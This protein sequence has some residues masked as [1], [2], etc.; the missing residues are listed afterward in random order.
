MACRASPST[1]ASSFA[2]KD[3]V[4]ACRV[5]VDRYREVAGITPDVKVSLPD[6][7][8]LEEDLAEAA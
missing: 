6:Q 2:P 7:G 1:T 5:L 8:N 4:L 3:H